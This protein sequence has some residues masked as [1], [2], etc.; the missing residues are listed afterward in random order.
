MKTLTFPP[1]LRWALLVSLT[2]PALALATNV[3]LQTSLGN[4]DIE[5]YDTAAPLT[6]ANFLGYMNKGAYNNTFIHRSVAGFVIQGGGYTYDGATNAVAKVVAGA[7]VVNEY[8]ASRSNLRGTIAMAKLGNNPNSATTEWFINLADNA[9][10]LD[11]QN[12]GF[13]VFGKVTGNGMNVIDA[14]ANLP[15]ANAGGAFTQIPVV[16]V[17]TSGTILQENLVMVKNV[18]VAPAAVAT[19]DLE[20]LFNYF[21][22]RYPQFLAPSNQPSKTDAGY[23]YRYYPATYA[24]LG[25]ASDTLYFLGPASGNTILPLGSVADWLATASRAGY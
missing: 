17:P 3:R 24:Y 19:I 25:T 4:V 22:A 11:T 21:E 7:P 9:A 13:T 15:I 20:R 6:V 23:Y 18:G 14:I 12:G 10:N 8:D 16:S 2:L 5:L 1:L